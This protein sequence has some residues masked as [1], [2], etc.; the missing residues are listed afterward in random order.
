VDIPNARWTLRKTGW[1]DRIRRKLGPRRWRLLL[2]GCCRG[3][4][5]EPV[6]DKVQEAFDTCDRF[7][8]T[9]QTKAALKRAR[10]FPLDNPN[11]NPPES[12][13]DTFIF[14]RL[15]DACD[16]LRDLL[17][18]ELKNEL[19]PRLGIGAQWTL[20]MRYSASR[21][22]L[23]RVLADF[24]P[25]ADAPK[26]LDPRWKTADVLALARGIYRD[27][28]FDRLPILADALMDAGCS[29]KAVPAHCRSKGAHVRGCWVLDL[30]LNGQWDSVWRGPQ[31]AARPKGPKPP[32][33]P[34]GSPFRL[35]PAVQRQLQEVMESGGRWPVAEAIARAY[36]EGLKYRREA[37]RNKM[38]YLGRSAAHAE[39]EFASECLLGH[40][41]GMAR[42]IARRVLLDDPRELAWYI[43]M[44]ARSEWINH[45]HDEKEPAGK[46]YV[47]LLAA[48]VGD[49][50]V[51]R[52]FRDWNPFPLRAGQPDEVCFY[53]ATYALAAGDLP[54]FRRLFPYRPRR[55]ADSYPVP[56]LACLGAVAANAPG[57]FRTSLEAMLE[58][59]RRSAMGRLGGLIDPYAHGVYEL[60]RRAAPTAVAA[61]DVN[62]PPPWD[63][64]FARWVR[65][66]D[67]AFA[68]FDWQAIPEEIRPGLRDL[69]R[70][71]WWDARP[72]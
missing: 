45:C 34:P 60:C 25:P 40:G 52:R 68:D 47:V 3:L 13:P 58:R 64:G 31:P 1:A 36:A 35:T 50:L 42:G 70:P 11:A 43:G 53:N 69:T 28:A 16:L 29:D 55:K 8:D 48:A 38:G 26:R 44:E 17:V 37:V 15:G 7:A 54:A 10:G 63:A 4:F 21:A 19:L 41:E 24:D 67:D 49:G 51:L 2:S 57:L 61:F 5:P 72:L 18:P 65:D 27:R 62:H 23:R 20:R 30:V 9:G 14:E 39:A 12:S 56:D 6:P 22:F 59:T 32:Q 33:A 71:V 46:L 66:R